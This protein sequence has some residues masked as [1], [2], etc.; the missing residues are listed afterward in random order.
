MSHNQ[1]IVQKELIETAFNQFRDFVNSLKPVDEKN[2][3]FFQIVFELM[4]ATLSNYHQ[5]KMG[6]ND[7]NN[8]SSGWECRN[9]LELKIFTKYVL[10]SETNARRFADDRLIDG[11]DIIISLRLLSYILIQNLILSYSMT[12]SLAC[13]LKWLLKARQRRNIWRPAR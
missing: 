9:L 8:Q 1:P 6:Y 12:D 11:C 2:G 13:K 4:Y 3:W 10:I 5:L 7:E